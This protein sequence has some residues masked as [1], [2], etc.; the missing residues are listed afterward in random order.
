M[1]KYTTVTLILALF[2]FFLACFLLYLLI[3]KQL[4]LHA[5]RAS[6]GDLNKRIKALT[7][8]LMDMVQQ[9]EDLERI[10]DMRSKFVSVVAHDL[11]QPLTLLNGYS[12]L[13]RENIKEEDRSIL[14][15]IDK[16]ALNIERLTNDLADVSAVEYG[17]IKLN[18]SKFV[19]NDL[20][21]EIFNQYRGV[22]A[23]KDIDMHLIDY[24]EKIMIEADRFRLGQV[25]NNL[26]NNALKFTAAGGNVEIKYSIEDNMVKTL[27]RDDGLGIT[28]TDRTKIF[29]KFQQSDF[30][31]DDFKKQGWG[32]GLSIADEIVTIHGGLIG[33]D[34][35]GRGAGATFWIILPIKH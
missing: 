6:I 24:P 30:I 18:F 35:A 32:L 8:N 29:D 3:R 1:D 12:S 22:A 4:A 5:E 21:E 27:I 26:L 11:K 2:F 34:S 10:N 7:R 33:A 31:E 9:K 20:I 16:A 17:R 19:F 23:R 13:L 15:N 25:F 28:H 14:D